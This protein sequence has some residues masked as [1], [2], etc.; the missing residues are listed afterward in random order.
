M[1]QEEMDRLVPQKLAELEKTYGISVLYAA[2]SGS[3]AWGFAS[4]DSDF[5]V[6][7]IYVRPVQDYLHLEEIRDVLEIPIDEVWDVCGWDLN[8]ALR[9]LRRSNPSLYEW[10]GSPIVYKTTPLWEK[11]IVPALSE[12]YQPERNLYHYRNMAQGNFSRHFSEADTAVKK[13][14]YVLRPILAGKWVVSH[15]C[16]PPV[17]FVDLLPL[18]DGSLRETVGELLHLKMQ[19]GEKDRIP[20]IPQ[21][22]AFIAHELEIL[23]NADL[24]EEEP[25]SWDK[26]NQLF[27]TILN[28]NGGKENAYDPGR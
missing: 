14:F 18:L 7:F 11:H 20:R 21:L 26:L 22:D 27:L 25:P 28:E 15:R 4:K 5:D 8:K 1:T 2:E 13:Y 19:A 9:L 24:P 16:P 23:K 3:R 6:R 12:C 17:P 10:A